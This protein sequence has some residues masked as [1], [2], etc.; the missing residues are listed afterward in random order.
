MHCHY[1]C[2]LFFP[3]IIFSNI[4]YKVYGSLYFNNYIFERS[5]EHFHAHYLQSVSSNSKIITEDKEKTEKVKF[6]SLTKPSYKTLI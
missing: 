6:K 5:V 1:H 3:R 2:Q 4:H